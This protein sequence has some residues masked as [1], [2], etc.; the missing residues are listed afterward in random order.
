MIQLHDF[1]TSPTSI[2]HKSWIP[3]PWQVLNWGL[4]QVGLGHVYS[5]QKLR[6][7]SLVLV[8]NVEDVAAKVL[9]EMQKKSSG[10]TDRVMAIESFQEDV[11]KM[12]GIPSIS[13]TDL[14]T[15]LKYLH[16]DK[17]V[18]SYDEKVGVF[19]DRSMNYL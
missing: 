9:A 2:Y 8:A 7:G 15:L 18:I 17:D 13:M 11:V 19:L 16:R 6:S 5:G 1:N 14:T 4:R 10:L 12:L 3:S